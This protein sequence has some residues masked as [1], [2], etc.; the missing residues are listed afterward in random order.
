M[1]YIKH[2]KEI[3]I[4]DVPVVG[5]KNASL[6]EM[7]QKLTSKGVNVPDG[8]ALDANA[9]WFFLKENSLEDKLSQVL[10]QL[11]TKQFSNLNIVGSQCRDLML[12]ASL[13]KELSVNLLEAYTNLKEKYGAKITMAVRSSATAEDLPNASFA[14]QQETFLNIGGAE[15][16]YCAVQ[17]CFASLFTDRAIKYREDNGFEHMK[18]ALSVLKFR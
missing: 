5:G 10:V 17:A 3:S 2:F 7:Y 11:D 16:L 4:E 1:K 9:Y 8:F 6:G 18:V 15:N 12:N 13:P 14:G